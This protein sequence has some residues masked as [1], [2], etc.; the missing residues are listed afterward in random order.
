LGKYLLGEVNNELIE[1]LPV[2]ADDASS[3]GPHQAENEEFVHLVD[4]VV[5]ALFGLWHHAVDEVAELLD[6]V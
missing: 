1:F 3:N 4:F 5:G 6:N 2:F